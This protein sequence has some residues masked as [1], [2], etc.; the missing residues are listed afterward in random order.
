MKIKIQSYGDSGA[1]AE[2]RIGFN[3]IADCDLQFF[4]VHY[5]HLTEKGGFFN[6]PKNT[7]WFAP[8]SVKA[9]DKIV[10]YTKSGVNSI[11]KENDGTTIYFYYWGLSN[12][13][14]NK[15]KDGIVLAEMSD[16]QTKWI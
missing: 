12:S 11:K 7:F 4:A 16:W 13:I 9:G 1:L 14:L 6:R 10:L 8:Q 3:V 2:E 5:T 15:E